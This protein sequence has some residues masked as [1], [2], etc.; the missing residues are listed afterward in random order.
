MP[1]T[2]RRKIIARLTREGWQLVRGGEH[3]KFTHPNKPG[4]L[5]VVP[6]HRELST[7]VARS[8]ARQADWLD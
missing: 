1:E 6:R 5:I 7:G 3:D 8:I 2:N 4:A